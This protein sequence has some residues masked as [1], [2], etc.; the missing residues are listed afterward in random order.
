MH[1]YCVNSIAQP[2][3][4]HE[5]HKDN[6]THGPSI[7]NGINLGPHP[8]DKSAL[9]AALAIYPQADGCFCCCPQIHKH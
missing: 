2:N 4:D 9:N 5:V 8:S 7:G 3:G 1:Y 6:C